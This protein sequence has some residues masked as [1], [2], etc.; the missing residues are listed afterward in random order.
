MAVE[1]WFSAE[2]SGGGGVG[3]FC[4]TAAGLG[5]LAMRLGGIARII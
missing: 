1:W 2:G 5:F 4:R 3:D